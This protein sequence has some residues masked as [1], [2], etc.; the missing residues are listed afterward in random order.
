MAL[1]SSS[2][3][4]RVLLISFAILMVTALVQAVIVVASGSV[5]LL[6]D[7]LHNV[8]D[9]LT[10]V[11]L[12]IAFWVGRRAATRRFTYGYGRAEDLAGIAIVLIIAASAGLAGH[13]AVKRLIDPQDVRALGWVAAAGLVGFLGNEWVARYRITVGRQI[14]SAA[15]VADG[16]HARTDGFTSLAVLL[17]AGGAALGFPIADPI[18][19]LLITVAICFV[20]RDAA[21][22]I[23]H[24]LMDAVDPVLVDRAEQVLSATSG[25]RRVGSVRLRWVGHALRAE[26]DIVVDPALSVVAAHT[27]AVQA[28]HRLIHELPRL[29]AAT[30]HADPDGPADAD[31]HAVLSDHR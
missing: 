1:E 22:E 8:A 6:G 26:V 13:E 18:I 5:A 3:G 16:L 19:G 31:H 10:A 23:Y 15:L 24:R 11:P 14:G 4:L 21:R 30:V 28:E 2:R 17:G 7:T 29:R 9:A 25:V 20:L 27:V 12:G